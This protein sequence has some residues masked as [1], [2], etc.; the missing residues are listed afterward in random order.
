MVLPA[1]TIPSA[2][3]RTK[4]QSEQKIDT[5]QVVFKIAERCNINCSYCYYFNM[6]ETS[7]KSRP[8][9]V[10][11]ETAKNLADWI[12]DGCRSQQI[13]NVSVAFHG[14]EPMMIRA[15]TFRSICSMMRETIEPVARLSFTIQTNGTILTDE[16]LDVF[17]EHD[18]HVGVSIDGTRTANDRYRLDHK[19]RSTF[20][21]IEAN[22]RRLVEWNNGQPRRGPS[23]IA[24]MDWRNDYREIYHYLRSLGVVQMNFLL[25]DRPFDDDLASGETL[26]AYGHAF[27]DIFSAWMEEDNQDVIIRQFREPLNALQ[28]KPKGMKIHHPQYQIVVAQSDGTIAINDSLI[29]ALEWYN[30]HHDYD[31]LKFSLEDFLASDD[32]QN[33]KSATSQCPEECS[34]CKWLGLCRAGDVESRFS[35]ENGFNNPSFYCKSYKTFYDAMCQMLVQNGFPPERLV[36]KLDNARCAFLRK[37]PAVN[38]VAN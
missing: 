30:H 6:G 4:S 2:G 17:S 14:G 25:P 36:E 35:S 33:L 37:T 7:P 5:L 8:P 20:D 3:N 31:V 10:S 32:H 12:V 1:P 19:G 28:A 38:Q 15:R 23:I 27:A 26:A 9:L 13:P 22:I 29:P 18:V 11:L 21:K 16:W 24:V 34:N